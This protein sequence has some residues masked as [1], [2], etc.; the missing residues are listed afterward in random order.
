MRSVRLPLDADGSHG[1]ER[2]RPTLVAAYGSTDSGGPGN[3]MIAIG[4]RAAFDLVV[5]RVG[6]NVDVG[7]SAV[8]TPALAVPMLFGKGQ[9][10]PA[11]DLSSFLVGLQFE[12]GFTTA[13]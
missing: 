10:G 6:L 4:G 1:V 11:D 13:F 12:A 9:G 3:V 8:F 2:T 5:P 7:R